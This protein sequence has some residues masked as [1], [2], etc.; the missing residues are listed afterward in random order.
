M[1]HYAFLV[2]PT[3]HKSNISKKLDIYFTRINDLF[4]KNTHN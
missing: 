3:Q 4:K 2:D 1:I